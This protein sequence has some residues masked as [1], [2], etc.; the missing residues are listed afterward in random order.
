[1]C[2]KG[3]RLKERERLRVRERESL[4]ERLGGKHRRA[5]EAVLSV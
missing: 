5:L 2:E 3:K 4:R 1:M